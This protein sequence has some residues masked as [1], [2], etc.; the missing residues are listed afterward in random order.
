VIF[1]EIGFFRSTQVSEHIENV[2]ASSDQIVTDVFLFLGLACDTL[3]AVATALLDC[4]VPHLSDM[5]SSIY[6]YISDSLGLFSYSDLSLR[7]GSC[8]AS[9]F[10]SLRT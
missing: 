9:G 5:R 1:T 3:T 10:V 7:Y 2:T 6:Q 8:C 4:A